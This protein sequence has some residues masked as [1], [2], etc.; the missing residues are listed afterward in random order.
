MSRRIDDP[1]LGTAT[2]T[3]VPSRVGTPPT[4]SREDAPPARTGPGRTLRE[5]RTRQARVVL[6]RVGPWSVFKFSLLFYFCVMLVVLLALGM[7]YAVMGAV[8][9]L[10]SITDF[11]GEL[12]SEESFAIHAGWIFARLTLIGLLMVVVWSLINVFIAF[13]YN[14]ISDVLGGVEITLSER[15]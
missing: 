3:A 9:A 1:G 13:L 10:D 5:P 15:R 8:G 4:V 12:F 2:P 11:L 7:L 14:L 6:R